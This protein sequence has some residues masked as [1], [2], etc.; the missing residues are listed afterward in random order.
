MVTQVKRSLLRM[1]EL[2][3]YCHLRPYITIELYIH[4][5]SSVGVFRSLRGWHSVEQ[6][7]QGVSRK[8]ACKVDR[9]FLSSKS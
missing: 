8:L 5:T 2:P 1:K 6:S 9:L 4:Y 3:L 7:H